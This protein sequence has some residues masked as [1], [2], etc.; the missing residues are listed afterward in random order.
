M[1]NQITM[2]KRL[3]LLTA[4]LLIV[5]GC[6]SQTAGTPAGNGEKTAAKTETASQQGEAEMS[7]Q[8]SRL[9]DYKPPSMNDVP[10]GPLGEAITYGHKLI[11]ETSTALPDYVGNKLSCSSCHGNAGMDA[12][13][14][15]TGVAAVYPQY[16]PRSGKVLTIEDRINGCFVRSMN[17]QPLPYDSDEMRAMVAYLSYISTD[18]PVGTKERPWVVKNSL[19]EVPT[20]SVENGE[21]LYKQSCIQ[22]HAAEGSGTGS[23]SGPALWGDNSFNIGAGMGRISTAA[24]YIKRNM[25]LGEMGGVKQGTLTDQEVADLAAYILSFPRPDFKD[26]ANDWPAGNAPKDVPY[27][28][29]SQKQ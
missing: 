2:R 16:I 25:P 19:K 11:N 29:N 21:R 27:E 20:P 28:L 3:P 12:T 15:L 10:E 8:P 6:S 4:A 9:K 24:G 5:A 18:V 14:P 26:K 17:G 13:S 1:A 7:A 22:C 23:N